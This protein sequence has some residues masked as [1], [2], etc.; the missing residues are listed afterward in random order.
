MVC[1]RHAACGMFHVALGRRS[2]RRW[3]DAAVG[4]SGRTGGGGG[5]SGGLGNTNAARRTCHLA[6]RHAHDAPPKLVQPI[7]AARARHSP[8]PI[9]AAATAALVAAALVAAAFATSV[10]APRL[11]HPPIAALERCRGRREVGR[12]SQ[13]VE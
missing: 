2:G 13:Q 3:A 9:P 10:R 12:I 5:G 6:D 8:H 4:R 1:W 7:L 11:Q